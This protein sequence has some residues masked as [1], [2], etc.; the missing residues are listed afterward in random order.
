MRITDCYSACKNLP[1]QHQVCW[2]HFNRKARE[3]SELKSLAKQKQQYCQKWYSQF[4][5]IYQQ[6]RDYL[7]EPFDLAER[8]KCKKKLLK[9]V[10]KLCIGHKLDPKKLTDLKNLMLEYEHALFTCLEVEGIPCDNNRAERDIRK[11]VLK[12]KKSF[13]CKTEKGAK[14]L[15]VILSVCCGSTRRLSFALYH[16]AFWSIFDY[17]SISLDFF[18]EFV[19]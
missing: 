18:T 14:A 13:G 17:K 11:L 3:L 2:A 19:R 7:K 5:I 8:D 4:G 9:A 15:E 16:H 1:G 10:K 6:L 12:R